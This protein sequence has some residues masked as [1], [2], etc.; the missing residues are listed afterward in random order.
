M[1]PLL[2]LNILMNKPPYSEIHRNFQHQRFHL[3]QGTQESSFI[4]KQTELPLLLVLSDCHHNDH[5]VHFNLSG[6]GHLPLQIYFLEEFHNDDLSNRK[7]LKLL[8][9]PCPFGWHSSDG[10]TS[11][12]P[13]FFRRTPSVKFQVMEAWTNPSP[14]S[15]FSGGLP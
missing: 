9:A 1:Y 13:I 7:L 6:Q 10:A 2:P 8:S 4:N 5:L 12:C 15:I 3:L 14:W 11:F